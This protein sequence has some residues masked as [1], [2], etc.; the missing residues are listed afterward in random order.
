MFQKVVKDCMG[1]Q[2]KFYFQCKTPKIFNIK[3]PRFS[4]LAL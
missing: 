4:I 3:F 1:N 2:E